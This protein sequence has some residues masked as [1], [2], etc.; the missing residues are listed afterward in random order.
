A[1]TSN[2]KENLYPEG[3]KDLVAGRKSSRERNRR[4]SPRELEIEQKLRQGVLIQY[5]NQPLG[6]VIDDLAKDTGT[7]IVL[8]PR[9]L[10]QAGVSGEARVTLNLSTDIQL[11]SALDLIAEP[12]PLSYVVTDGVLKIASVGLRDGEIVTET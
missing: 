8:D 11:K 5:Q 10:S 9:G 4:R 12:L 6:A 1:E 7:N 3:W 2:G